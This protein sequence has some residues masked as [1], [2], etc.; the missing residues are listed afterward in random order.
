ML[1]EG[2]FVRIPRMEL[3]K[4]STEREGSLLK[5]GLF[6]GFE[7]LE[8]KRQRESGFIGQGVT[9]S[10]EKVGEGDGGANGPGQKPQG[11]EERA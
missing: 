3:W 1:E 4:A 8:A 11:E 10:C 7:C 6:E 2:L 5:N 9:G